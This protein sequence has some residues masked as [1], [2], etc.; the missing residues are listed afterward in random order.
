M[1]V[2]ARAFAVTSTASALIFLFA[3]TFGF[4]SPSP[5]PSGIA[6]VADDARTIARTQ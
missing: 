2:F 1:P 4:V 6:P 5:R 3:L